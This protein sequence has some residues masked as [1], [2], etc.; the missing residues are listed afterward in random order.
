MEE[1]LYSIGKVAKMM[2]CSVATLRRWEKEGK[3]RSVRTPG[4]HRKFPKEVLDRLLGGEPSWDHGSASAHSI[5]MAE[6]RRFF[7]VTTEIPVH[8]VVPR[9]GKRATRELDGLV[10]NLNVA[11]AFIGTDTPISAA[12]HRDIVLELGG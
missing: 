12:E 3:I 2:G 6:R 9:S 7:R 5:S 11:G 10:K 4:G 8:M 1:R